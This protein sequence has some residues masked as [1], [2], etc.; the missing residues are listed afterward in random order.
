MKET[1]QI[2]SEIEQLEAKLRDARYRL[3]EAGL[4]QMGLQVGDRIEVLGKIVEVTGSLGAD[5]GN[6]RPE[7]V[8]VKKD[9][10]AGQNS[11]G[12]IPENEWKKL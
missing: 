3:N 8:Y 2:R 6:P 12:F 1:H 4:R 5:Y 7:G 9:G 11:A 10:T